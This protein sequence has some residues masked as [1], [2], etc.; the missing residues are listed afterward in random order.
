[1]FQKNNLQIGIGLGLCL[2]MLVLGLLSLLNLAFG[3]VLRPRT[4]ALIAI[5]ANML[6]VQPFRKRYFYQ[7][8]QG[9]IYATIGLGILWFV[10]H[11][12]EIMQEF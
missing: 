11:G 4:L 5:S 1:M 9:V 6:L 3:G 7:S 10:W 12:Q 8:M 2:P